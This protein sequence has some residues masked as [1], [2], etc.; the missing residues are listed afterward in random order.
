MKLLSNKG[1]VLVEYILLMVIAVSCAT[2]L[3]KALIGRSG[4][5]A[6]GSNSSGIIIK[7]WDKILNVLGNDLPACAN[8][9][10]F[11]KPQCP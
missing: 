11:K 5:P 7:Q 1:Q 3:I 6:T 2:I 9:S 10:D 8:Q 4:D